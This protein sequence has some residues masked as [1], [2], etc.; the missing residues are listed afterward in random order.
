MPLATVAG[1]RSALVGALALAALGLVL[2][3]GS[4]EPGTAAP[5]TTTAVTTPAPAAGEEDVIRGGSGSSA[6]GAPAKG[7]R[8]PAIVGTTLDG[9]TISLA[10]YRGKKVIVNLWS[11]W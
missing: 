4:D 5:P 9:E 11:S 7:E 2:G 10:D 1:V 3:C 8:A 6:S